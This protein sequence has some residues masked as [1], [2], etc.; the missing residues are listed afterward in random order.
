M[1][2]MHLGGLIGGCVLVAVII[3]KVV[4]TKLLSNLILIIVAL[5]V[6][7]KVFMAVSQRAS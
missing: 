1:T 4:G 2:N 7:G 5:W 3:A 6:V